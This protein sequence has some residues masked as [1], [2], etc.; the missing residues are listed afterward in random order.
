MDTFKRVLLTVGIILFRTAKMVGAGVGVIFLC[1][2]TLLSFSWVVGFLI[3]PFF[4]TTPIMERGFIALLGSMCGVG[5]IVV[6]LT[7][8]RDVGEFIRDVWFETYYRM[9]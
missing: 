9:K 3:T 8:L 6:L 4:P 2:I 7:L 1:I 5:G